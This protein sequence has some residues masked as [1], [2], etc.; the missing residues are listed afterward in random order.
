MIF[1]V[2]VR[3]PELTVRL[4]ISPLPIEVDGFDVRPS[5]GSTLSISRID[6]TDLTAAQ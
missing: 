2:T 5:F 4:A 1:V 3:Q 6:T